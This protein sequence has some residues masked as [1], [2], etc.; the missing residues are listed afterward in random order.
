M[1]KEVVVT[2]HSLFRHYINFYCSNYQYTEADIEKLYTYKQAWHFYNKKD[3]SPV[4]Y[5][6]LLV[7]HPS[8]LPGNLTWAQAIAKQ[9]VVLVVYFDDFDM[10]SNTNP[11]KRMFSLYVNPFLDYFH[12]EIKRYIRH[13]NQ[14]AHLNIL[15]YNSHTKPELT[16]NFLKIC[17]M[18]KKPLK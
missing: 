2:I 12:A 11:E 9:I 15:R 13:P 18:L 7:P 10:I 17:Y 8:V 3:S 16:A 6:I 4:A 14:R 1:S 5:N